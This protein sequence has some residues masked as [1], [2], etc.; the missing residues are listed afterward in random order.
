MKTHLHREVEQ[1]KVR[2]LELGTRVEESLECACRAIHERDVSLAESVTDGDEAID[3]MEVD[4]EED[5]LQILA[6]YQPV[7]RD[8]RF[9]VAVLKLNNDLERIG[10]LAVNI[11]K[12]GQRLSEL[13]PLPMPFDFVA[14]STKVRSML[15][16]SLDA[17]VNLDSDL[18]RSVCAADEEI[19][20]M[21]RAVYTEVS[22]RLR[23]DVDRVD[24]LIP[25]LTIAR[26]L[27]RVADHATNIAEDVIYMVE[28]EISR[29]RLA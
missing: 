29:H 11:A 19:D 9:I 24:V 7:A 12:R 14:M 22:R 18:A 25:M 5:C 17:I 15:K 20:D 28:G 3:R 2:V 10:D 26:H 23:E 27:E 16:R 6:L 4:V 21:H 13:P 8:L 1:L